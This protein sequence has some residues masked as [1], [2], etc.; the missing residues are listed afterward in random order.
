MIFYAGPDVLSGLFTLAN[1]DLAESNGVIAPFGSGC[2]AIV[3]Y[4]TLQAGAARPKCILGMF[5]VTAR[6][7][8]PANT[9]T[10]TAPTSRFEQMVAN[11]DE[12][13]LTTG[14]WEAVRGRL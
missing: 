13:F 3:E 9:L 8:V 6:P 2:A 11:M 7:F 12:S 10:F 4:P 5:D 14:A 1:Y